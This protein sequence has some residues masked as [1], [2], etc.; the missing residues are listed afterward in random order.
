MRAGNNS[1][2]QNPEADLTPVVRTFWHGAFSPY[3]ALC[4][5]TFAAAGI[6]VELF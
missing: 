3:E 5:R 4:L 1:I 6:R 2:G